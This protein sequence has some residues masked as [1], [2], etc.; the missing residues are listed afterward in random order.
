MFEVLQSK[1]G[2][3]GVDDAGV[4]DLITVAARAQNAQCARELAAIGE[5]YVRRAPA[6][7]AERF[8]WI[9][10]GH[11]NVVAEVAAALG[12]SR[13]RAA[14][15]L[16]YAIALRER[17]PRVAEAFAQGDIDFRLM[18]AVV[19]RTELVEDPELIARL[20]AA[21]ARHA[22]KWM[23]LSEPKMAER[24]DM[25]VA[26]CDPAGV[27]VPGLR[28]EDRYVEIGP[29]SPGLA[30]IWA[31]LHSTDGAA[32]DS[33]LDALAASVCRNDPRTAAQR[34]ADAL[35][36]LAA[37]Q[38]ALRCACD[39][40]D[41]AAAQRYPGTSVVIH[42]LAEPAA[43]IGESPAP[44]YLPAF[45]PLP[46]TLLRDLAGVAK[47]KPLSIPPDRAEVGY[48]PSAALAEFIRF[49][50]L[51]CRFPG[52]DAPAD[53]C[54]IDHT[55]PFPLG[56]THPSNLK[57][58]CRHHHLLKTFYTGFDG[59]QDRQRPDGTVVWTSPTGHTYTT[60]P[61][62][63]LYFP[64][65]AMP[66]G[67]LASPTFVAPTQRNRGVMMPVRQR[68]RA[69]DRTARIRWERGINE[70]RIVAEAARDAERLAP[71]NNDPPPF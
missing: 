9:V 62:G 31:K 55:V 50:D 37:G 22:P 19:Y 1:L 56:P 7:D 44:A 70:A 59:W 17:L 2:L 54:D 61:G 36:A 30:G 69:Q 8:N 13:G 65:L 46:T 52:C 27:R 53:L 34:R 11:E 64:A 14:G 63:S 28:T 68:T 21:V 41:C 20:D 16:R 38:D 57:L 4:V 40:P 29:I 39:T 10:D 25:W 3:R 67:T 32:L 12:I 15:R 51:T 18:A 71:N 58:L 66:T 43:V 49:R 23:R 26:R 45:G 35:G 60:K 48:R 47:S 33:R 6:D 24:I 42:V 5:L